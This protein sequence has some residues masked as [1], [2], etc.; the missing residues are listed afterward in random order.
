MKL[1]KKLLGLDEDYVSPID[2]FLTELNEVYPKKSPSQQA[3]I[4]K[5]ERVDYLRDHVVATTNKNNI[6][7]EF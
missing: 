2:R 3:E 6:W 5:Y 4:K 7:Q 1:I